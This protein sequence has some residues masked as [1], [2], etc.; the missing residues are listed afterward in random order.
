M[1]KDFSR[2]CVMAGLCLGLA[3]P[4]QAG[5]F[6]RLGGKSNGG[7][8][9]GG[10]PVAGH[11]DG[12]LWSCQGVANRM[13][14]LC[15]MAHLGNPAGGFEGVGCA[16]TAEAAL[17]NTCRPRSG[18]NPRDWGVAQGANGLWYACRRW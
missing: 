9:S 8:G 2:F 17:A 10:Q 11:S 6:G 13:A 3:L 1:F 5:P 12:E 7:N 18:G 16:G 15:R 14:R 4:A